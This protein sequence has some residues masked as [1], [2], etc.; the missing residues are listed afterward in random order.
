MKLSSLVV[1]A[2]VG[3]PILSDATRA[4]VPGRG[5]TTNGNVQNGKRLYDRDGCYECHG[6]A[7]QG[8]GAGPRIAATNLSMQVL[9]RYVRRPFGAMPAYTEKVLSDL[10]LMDIFAYLKTLPSAKQSK[11]IP[12]LNQLRDN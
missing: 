5:Q 2:T 3:L 7:A 8:S 4:Q 10:E 1:L 6:Y 9:M 11:E 12:L